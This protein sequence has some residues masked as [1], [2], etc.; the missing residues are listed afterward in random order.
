MR[1][2]LYAIV[3]LLLLWACGQR[4]SGAYMV[5]VEPQRWLL[6]QLVDSGAT[7]DVMLARGTDPE[8][9][10]PAMGQRMAADDAVAYFSTGLL[11]FEKK[12]AES[13]HGNYIEALDGVKLIYGTHEHADHRGHVHDNDIPDPHVWTSPRRMAAMAKAMT[14][15]LVKLSPAQTD[16]YN[17]RL[18]SLTA[19]LDSIDAATASALAGAGVRSFAVWHPFLS[20]FA[21][22]YG[23]S[24]IVVGQ[25]GKEMSAMQ[26]KDAIDRARE[27]GV[28]VLFVE[29]SN[30]PRQASVIAE[31]IGA[32]LVTVDPLA[33]DFEQQLSLITD[34]LT[35]P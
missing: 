6:E 3:A 14:G 2:C 13:M 23:L 19:R 29:R 17:A 10:E 32:R 30:D 25:D 9:A 35:R 24:Q 31:G 18:A 11:P 4:R 15:E 16:E 8:T 12:L 20:Y 5:S 26:I 7:V 34:E 27:A 33:Y 28:K 21:A 1:K 22:D